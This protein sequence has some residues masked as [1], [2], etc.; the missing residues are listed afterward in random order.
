MRTRGWVLGLVLGAFALAACVRTDEPLGLGGET[1]W[2]RV[3]GDDGDCVSGT[4]E[5]GVCTIA[6]G[7]GAGCTDEFEGACVIPESRIAAACVGPVP[8]GGMC[9][10]TC[11]SDRACGAGFACRDGVCVEESTARRV[12]DEPE[13]CPLGDSPDCP[14]GLCTWEAVQ[15]LL[16]DCYIPFVTAYRAARCGGHDAILV[17]GTDSVTTYFFDR[18]GALVGRSSAGIEGLMCAAFDPSFTSPPICD[19][20]TPDCSIEAMPCDCAASVHSLAC[21]CDEVTCEPF[22]GFDGGSQCDEPS[23][24]EPKVVER[25]CGNAIVSSGSP[26]GRR[27]LVYRGPANVLAGASAS[28]DAPF[29]ACDRHEYATEILDLTRCDDYSVCAI[30]D[31]PGYKTCRPE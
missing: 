15:V 4:C 26:F 17:Q 14:E 16:P 11:S 5:C 19:P 2:L 28:Q 23:E 25:G 13:S 12:D 8:S 27:S 24:M 29:G 7:E 22:V 10:P 6:C 31:T 30:C 3:C 1:N 9:L 18:S 20:A 21:V